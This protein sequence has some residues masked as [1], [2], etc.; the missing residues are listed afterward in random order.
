MNWTNITFFQS[1]TAPSYRQ[2]HALGLALLTLVADTS[3]F[4][5]QPAASN[6]ASP[7]PLAA[8]ASPAWER[9]FFQNCAFVC[10]DIQPGQRSH[11]SEADVPKLWRKAGFTAADVNAASDYA[12]DVAYPNARKVVDA[13]RSLRLPMIFVHW[14]CRFRDG[15]DLDPEVRKELLGQ[16]GTNYS[17]W[18]HCVQDAN[19]RPA[20]ELGVRS[21]EYVLPKSGQDAFRSS[22]IGFLLTNLNVRNIVFIGGHTEACLG[23]TAQSAKQRGF[24]MLCVEDAT[25]NARES[26]RQKGIEQA[27]YDHVVTTEQFLKLAKEACETL[28]PPDTKTA[29]TPHPN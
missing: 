4:S 14:G 3:A 26:T 2:R 22:N 15:M 7:D 25:F 24:R 21:G 23:R 17:V 10:V 5:Q 11:M 1:R 29:T 16:H 18:G 8:T 28:A 9:E 20:D 12:F 27:K 6:P 19:A 13:C